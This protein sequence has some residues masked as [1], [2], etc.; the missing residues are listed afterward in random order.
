[1]NGAFVGFEHCHDETPALFMQ[2]V[3][4]AAA[5]QPEEQEGDRANERRQAKAIKK[6][7]RDV[8]GTLKEFGN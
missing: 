3:Q 1:M 4:H 5:P 8:R 6:F 7:D 2:A